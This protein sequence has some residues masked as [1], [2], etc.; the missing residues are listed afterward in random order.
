MP[1]ANIVGDIPHPSASSFMPCHTFFPS[2]FKILQRRCFV[3]RDVTIF[4][5]CLE[6]RDFFVPKCLHDDT[7]RL[8]A[9]VIGAAK[10]RIRSHPV[11]WRRPPFGGAPA[12]YQCEKG[13]PPTGGR[14]KPEAGYEVAPR[15]GCV[16]DPTYDSSNGAIPRADFHGLLPLLVFFVFLRFSLFHIRR[17]ISLPPPR[18]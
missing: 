18:S 10:S 13:A 1:W 6:K 5:P 8:K 16:P 3:R 7:T 9:W 15:R 17:G 12:L 11:L 4:Q 14:K 2:A